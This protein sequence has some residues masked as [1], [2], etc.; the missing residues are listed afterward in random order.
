MSGASSSASAW[1]G[2]RTVGAPQARTVAAPQARKRK[3]VAVEELLE[4][5]DLRARVLVESP[6]DDPDQY[7]VC[8]DTLERVVLPSG[9]TWTVLEFAD[10]EGVALV[11]G[12]RLHAT[13]VA[14]DLFSQKLRKTKVDALVVEENREGHPHR[15]SLTQKMKMHEF[16]EVVLQA[17]AL[18]GTLGFHAF[19]LSVPQGGCHYFWDVFKLF[20]ILKLKSYKGKPSGWWWSG[21]GSWLRYVQGYLPTGNSILHSRR[22]MKEEFHLPTDMT[23]RFLARPSLSTFS[24]FSLASRWHKLSAKN[25]G[26]VRDVDREA[27][28]DLLKSISRA[29]LA[30]GGFEVPLRACASWAPPWPCRESSPEDATLVVTDEGTVDLSCLNDKELPSEAVTWWKVL[31]RANVI[32]PG[33]AVVTVMA[34]LAATVGVKALRPL[35]VQVAWFAAVRL[36]HC[37]SQRLAGQPPC[38][39]AVLQVKSLNLL[40]LVK[41]PERLGHELLKYVI[42]CKGASA[43][44]KR[45]NFFFST[46]KVSLGYTSVTNTFIG[47]SKMLMLCCPRVMGGS[48]TY[49]LRPGVGG[50][51]VINRRCEKKRCLSVV[52]CVAPPVGKSKDQR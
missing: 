13:I 30:Y 49:T 41:V 6:F 39:A 40:D 12:S 37:M 27:A 21:H 50:L 29:T 10:E 9:G 42:G 2:A 48:G 19:R 26:F 1:I 14:E 24:L 45:N 35:F 11:D 43:R 25:G 47:L 3:A 36:E 51:P 32:K 23:Y 34:L 15:W 28:G 8:I 20:R 46:D 44:R 22:I 5:V 31:V 7:A 52:I 17:G 18:L 16:L 4:D 38:N 33:A